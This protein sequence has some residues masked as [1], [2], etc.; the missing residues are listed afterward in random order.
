MT[1]SARAATIYAGTSQVQR[2]IIGE[3]LLGPPKEP[4]MDA[5]RE[6]PPLR[7]AEA[8]HQFPYENERSDEAF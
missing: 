4:K 3:Q 1:L 7:G 8:V 6:H 2:N 5:G